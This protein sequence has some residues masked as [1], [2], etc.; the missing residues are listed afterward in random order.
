[1]MANGWKTPKQIQE[2]YQIADKTW[3][4]WRSQCEASPYR[5]AIIRVSARSTFVVE[6][7]WQKFLMWRAQKFKEEHLDPHV[8]QIFEEEKL[9]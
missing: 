4:T 2:D 9:K 3:A 5:D 7:K 6:S 8:R 1:M